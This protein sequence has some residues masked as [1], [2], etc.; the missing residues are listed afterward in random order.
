MRIY[1]DNGLIVCAYP[2]ESSADGYGAIANCTGFDG[3]NNVSALAINSLNSAVALIVD[4]DRSLPGCYLNR[5]RTEIDGGND[6]IGGRIDA[7][8]FV[9]P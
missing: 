1:L 5:M 4:P 2:D 7:I 3:S 9:V 8:E 6:V